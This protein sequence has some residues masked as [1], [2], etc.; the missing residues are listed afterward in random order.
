MRRVAFNLY[1]WGTLVLLALSEVTLAAAAPDTNL[2]HLLRG[3]YQASLIATC[4]SDSVGFGE[5]LQ[6]LGTGTSFEITVSGVLH[7]NGDGTG[8]FS[9]HRMRILDGG[10]GPF[11]VF[12]ADGDC[13]LTYTLN[14]DRTFTQ[15]ANCTSTVLK[16]LASP[17]QTL[18]ENGVRLEGY[19]AAG[20][21]VLV[22]SNTS[23]VQETV[24]FTGSPPI[25]QK[26]I[27]GYS[28]TAVR[29]PS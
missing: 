5:N 4:V 27:C 3:D 26:R 14:V 12:E 23:P 25:T 18:T 22:L 21:G 15:Q 1:K 6:R 8:N 7:Y 13:T 17:P 20:L 16:G 11:P 28:G 10:P 2:N 9:N 29:W 19:I 24:S